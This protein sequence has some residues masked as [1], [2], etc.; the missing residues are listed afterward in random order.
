MNIMQRVFRKINE[1]INGLELSGFKQFHHLFEKKKGLE[2]GG[3]SGIFKKRN[4][5]ALYNLA[6]TVDGC[7]FSTNTVWEGSI[8]EGNNYSYQEGKPK[9]YQF[10]CE[11]SN[12]EPVESG[13][14]DFVLSSHNLEHFA[15]PLKAVEEWLRVLKPDGTI[16]LV[17][18]DKRFTFDNKRQVTSFAHIKSDY[19]SN[20]QEDDL[21]HLNEILELHDFLLSPEINDKEFYNRSLKNFE[22]RCL[23]HHVFDEQLLRQIFSF[24]NIEF[25]Y[26]DFASP[27]HLIIMGK[28]VA[29]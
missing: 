8:K 18:P 7:N 19:D 27:F 14:Y 25:L 23:H 1:K 2:I 21:T 26:T 24:F 22:N 6:D 10:I 5:L 17:L 16:L 20:M 12:L 15:N 3:P 28:K 11:G 13:S 29:Y 9:G 4:R